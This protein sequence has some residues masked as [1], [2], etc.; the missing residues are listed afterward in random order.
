MIPQCKNAGESSQ[1]IE[2]QE[3]DDNY[4]KLDWEMVLYPTKHSCNIN[5]LNLAF[6]II[7][8]TTQLKS[9]IKI[10]TINTRNKTEGYSNKECAIERGHKRG[11]L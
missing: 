11:Q 4:D 3:D 5:L 2:L 10:T 6:T 9:S 7:S 8:S 1:S